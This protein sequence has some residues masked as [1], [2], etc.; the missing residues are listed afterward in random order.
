MSELNLEPLFSEGRKVPAYFRRQ[1]R[2]LQAEKEALIAR[3]ARLEKE[4]CDSDTRVDTRV[5]LKPEE[6]NEILEA[7]EEAIYLLSPTE[8]DMQKKAGVYRVVTAFGRA[9][10]VAERCIEN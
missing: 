10:D 9:L 6:F 5:R 3:V 8:K 7:F 1:M 2:R 4:K